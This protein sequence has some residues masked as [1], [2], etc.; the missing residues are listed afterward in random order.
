MD[1]EFKAGNE[2]DIAS[3][4]RVVPHASPNRIG[5]QS[6]DRSMRGDQPCLFG[7]KFASFSGFFRSGRRCLRPLLMLSF[8]TWF[9]KRHIS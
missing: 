7:D 4:R 1:V 2:G 6:P 8:T 5:L 3:R 9:P